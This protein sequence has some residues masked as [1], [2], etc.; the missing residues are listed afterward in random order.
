LK[1]ACAGDESLRKEVEALLANLTQAEGFMKDPA[2]EVAANALARDRAVVA[3]CMV[4]DS[5]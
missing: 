4:R 5:S 3:Y 2:M 1:E